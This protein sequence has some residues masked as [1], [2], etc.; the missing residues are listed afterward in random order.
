MGSTFSYHRLGKQGYNR[1]GEE[2]S[3]T[4][5]NSEVAKVFQDIADLLELKGENVFKIRA[6]QKAARAIEHYPKETIVWIN[7]GVALNNAGKQIEAIRCFD[8]VIDI[9][10]QDADAWCQK[11]VSFGLLKWFEEALECFE[12]SIDINSARSTK[13][14]DIEETAL[15]TNLE[16]ADEI[17]LQHRRSA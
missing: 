4:M 5:K 11:G 13:G 12:T 10:P 1:G 8:I 6:Y 16:A 9:D 17:A 7:K 14:G 15:N 2:A 3:K